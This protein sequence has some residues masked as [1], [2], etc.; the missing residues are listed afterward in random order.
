MRWLAVIAE[1]QGQLDEA[2]ALYEETRD[3]AKKIGDV[4]GL[5]SSLHQ[6]AQVFL[7]RGEL[8][9]A[10]AL[11]QESLQLKEQIGDIQGKAASLHQMANILIAQ[12]EWS[13]AERI[14]Q[15][16]LTLSQ[17]VGSLEDMAFATVK[18]GQVAA[19]QDDRETALA[20]FREGLA[21]FERLGMPRETAQVSEMITALERGNPATADPLSQ[22]IAQ[23]RAA[24]QRGEMAAA[25][26]AQEEAVALLRRASDG[27]DALVALSVLLFNL[28]GYY[29]NA[30]RYDDAV[31]A[32]E[33]VVALDEQTGHEDLESDRAALE[34]AR[35]LAALSPE[36]RASLSQQQ[37]AQTTFAGLLQ[38]ARH[39]AERGDLAA[40]VIAQEEAVR[41]LRTNGND[42]DVLLTLSIQ[43][44]NLAGF[45]SNA[46]RYEAAVQALEEVERLNEQ[47][48][49][50]ELG[51]L[52]PRA[53]AEARQM[54]ALSPA[55]R[56]HLLAQAR[57][58]AEALAQM[59]EEERA[60]LMAAA[61]RA[62]IETLAS[63]TRDVAIAALRG[64][65][66]A[67]ELAAQM[68]EV[69]NRAA[70]GEEAGSP[71]LEVA[72]FARAAAAVLR[73]EPPPPVP[74]AYAVHFAAILEHL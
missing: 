32:L 21:V 52:A 14:L 31:L 49:H 68:E 50:P 8:D 40:A 66:D 7:T 23:A 58:A 38:D 11:Y 63:Q 47:T 10:L 54:A 67:L 57:Q 46:E 72:A 51:Q 16:S 64:E 3:I 45:Y 59:S 9:R 70:A 24:A 60:G 36:E 29:R 1:Q 39:A 20:R 19:A 34:Q 28:A 61:Q 17:K 62:P 33:E 44:Y 43:L 13:R 35:Q 71:W 4:G 53:L 37:G 22:A 30:G 48:G 65:A 55:E 6:M 27:R 41:L 15:E 2:L 42:P 5:S 25:I 69:A 74:T 26:A 56:E 73:G 18:L 12:D